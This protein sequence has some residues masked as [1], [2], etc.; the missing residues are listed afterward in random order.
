MAGRKRADFTPFSARVENVFYFSRNNG[1]HFVASQLN[2]KRC[3]KERGLVSIITIISRKMYDYR[4]G[5]SDSS[6]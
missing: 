6:L 4:V 5:H 3:R 1:H 2:G